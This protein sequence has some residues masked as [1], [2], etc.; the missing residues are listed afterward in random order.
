MKDRALAFAGL[1]QAC[2]LVRQIADTGDAQTAPLTASIDS[3]FRF[4]AESVEDVYGGAASLRPGLQALV[5]QIDGGSERDP[6]LLRL[7]ASVLRVERSY[8]ADRA[9]SEKLREGLEQAARQREHWGPT[10]PTVLTRLG[11][12]YA[13]TI[14]GLRPRIMVQGNP[15]YLQQPTVVAEIRAIL[16]CAL[17]SAVLW[18]Q[19]GGSQWDLYLRRPQMLGA[20][21]DW[22]D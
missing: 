16:L 18:R 13:A 1:V 21:R 22:L 2:R 15:V 12:L 11:E 19:L 9:L 8:S 4:D 3:L 20:A 5:A 10:H 6:M 14:S 17:R 7:L